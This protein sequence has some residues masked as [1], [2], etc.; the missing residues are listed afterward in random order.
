MDIVSDL[1]FKLQVIKQFPK[2]SYQNA[3]FFLKNF[4]FFFNCVIL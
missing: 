1:P 4:N 2:V 3:T